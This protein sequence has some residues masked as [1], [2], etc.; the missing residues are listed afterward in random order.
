MKSVLITNT[1]HVIWEKSWLLLDCACSRT[2]IMHF[3][4]R[5]SDP[6]LD[7]ISGEHHDKE[8]GTEDIKQAGR[9]EDWRGLGW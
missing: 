9:K 2:Y 4:N 7:S 6:M 1:K 8:S 5:I 3:P